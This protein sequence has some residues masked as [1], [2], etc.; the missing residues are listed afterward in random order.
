MMYRVDGRPS[1]A[2]LFIA[3][4]II[5]WVVE[6]GYAHLAIRVDCRAAAAQSAVWVMVYKLLTL[7]MDAQ[8]TRHKA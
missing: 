3:M 6:D 1:L 7:P 2:G 8:L 5:S 4:R